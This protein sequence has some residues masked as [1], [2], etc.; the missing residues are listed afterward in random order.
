MEIGSKIWNFMQTYFLNDSIY[1]LS[2]QGALIAI[3]EI[4]WCSKLQYAFTRQIDYLGKHKYLYL[5]IIMFTS[6]IQP[7]LIHKTCL[8]YI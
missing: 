6:N 5:Y 2:F 4:K 7:F 8:M 3:Q 1:D